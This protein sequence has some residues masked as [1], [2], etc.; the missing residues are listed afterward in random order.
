MAETVPLPQELDP[1]TVKLPEVAPAE[2]PAV[3]EAVFPDGVK[4]VP[5]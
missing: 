2:N 5:E 3:M 1:L 4:P